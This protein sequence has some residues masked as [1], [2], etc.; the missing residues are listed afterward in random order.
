[1]AASF[2]KRI[3]LFFLIILAV[4]ASYGGGRLYYHI[5]HGFSISNIT[6]NF[7]Y[8]SRWEVH[9]PTIEQQQQLNQIFAQK[10]SYLGKGCQSY[11]F[12]SE[13][14]EYVLKFF[15]YQR[16]R[17]QPWIDWFSF[18]P[19][20]EQYR[21]EKLTKKQEKLERFFNSWKL[22]YDELQPETGIVFVHLN[23]SN[24]LPNTLTITDKMGFE[25]I[26]DPN[27]MEF[28]LQRKAVM[29]CSTIKEL[30]DHNQVTETKQLLNAVVDLVL[31][32]NSRGYADNDH[33]LMQNTGILDGK[34]IHIDVGQLLKDPIYQ[35]PEKYKQELF[36]KTYKFRKWLKSH[37]PELVT[38]LETR[39][40][41]IIGPQFASMQPHFKPHE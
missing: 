9:T 28:M 21:L 4:S 24:H 8:D 16:F 40:I 26:L 29:L 33:A 14:G 18:I 31:S 37:Y 27:Q 38:Y 3:K 1:M 11:V 22:A 6:S 12:L 17:N 15:K 19:W 39:L 30:M 7:A 5:T 34:P 25:H 20:V 41:E 35:N 2:N 23:K 10:F 36:N 13:D 32:E